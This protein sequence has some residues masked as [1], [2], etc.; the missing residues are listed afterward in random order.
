MQNANI[1]TFSS[2]AQ[3]YF[4]CFNYETSKLFKLYDHF[5]LYKAIL[6]MANNFV[7]LLKAK[8]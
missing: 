7:L 6:K 3:V 5:H 4:L 8:F 2:T 1:Y